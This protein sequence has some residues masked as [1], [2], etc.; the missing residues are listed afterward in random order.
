MAEEA[1][2]TGLQRP[3]ERECVP[4]KPNGP[5]VSIICIFHQEE[6]FLAEAIESV[7]AQEWTDWE[8]ILADDGSTDRGTAIALEYCNRHPGRIRYIDHPGHANR[9]M[10]ATRNLGLTQARGELIAFIDGDDAWVPA[11]L[12]EQVAILDGNPRLGAVFGSLT[13]WESWSGGTDFVEASGHVSDRVVEPPEAL[14]RLYPLSTM[15]GGGGADLLV[16]RAAVDLA[17]GFAEEFT[18]LYEDQAFFVKLYMRVP[19]MFSSRSWVYY[20]RH[21]DSCVVVTHAAGLYLPWRRRFLVWLEGQLDPLSPP[22]RKRAR[23]AIAREL[24]KADHPRIGRAITFV[25][26]RWDRLRRRLNRAWD[27]RATGAALSPPSETGS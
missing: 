23:S 21:P 22:M 19:V 3:L 5:R 8:L 1:L 2:G 13:Y 9:G 6:R 16:R 24:W 7:L 27:A 17:G 11:K 12:L 20:R 4:G 26:H 15:P 10:S 25:Q 18:G 14:F